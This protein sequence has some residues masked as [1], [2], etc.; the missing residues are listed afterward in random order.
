MRHLKKLPLIVGAFFFVIGALI[1]V[2]DGLFMWQYG[3]DFSDAAF[4]T[5]GGQVADWPSGE[6]PTWACLPAGTYS[7]GFV[8]LGASALALWP[9]AGREY[10]GRVWRG[11][12]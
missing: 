6:R 12:E 11:T 9:K 4:V 7:L 8:L 10:R 3:V 5:E 1:F 2:G